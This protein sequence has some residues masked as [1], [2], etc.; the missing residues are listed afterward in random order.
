MSTKELKIEV[1]PVNIGLALRDWEFVRGGGTKNYQLDLSRP[2]SS[3]QIDVE[4]ARQYWRARQVEEAI[5]TFGNTR[6]LQTMVSD[7]M[8]YVVT[9]PTRPL[10]YFSGCPR[11]TEGVW[12]LKAQIK[13][14]EAAIEAR[15]QASEGYP[16]VVKAEA[17]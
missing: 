13:A 15:L 7:L 4:T 2:L 3:G 11:G 5:G 8:W 10:E 1:C 9:N 6:Y 12:L 16:Q 17:A 14:V